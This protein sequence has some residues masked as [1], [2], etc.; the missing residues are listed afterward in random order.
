ARAGRAVPEAVVLLGH[1]QPPTLHDP[2]GPDHP[3]TLARRT[4]LVPV[5]RQQRHARGHEQPRPGR[6]GPGSRLSLPPELHH[7]GLPR[8]R[9]AQ[10]PATHVKQRGGSYRMNGMV[11][12]L[13]GPTSAHVTW[14]KEL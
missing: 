10:L 6:Q 2:G 5:P 12:A 7:H 1:A 14:D 8:M 9:E 13:L 3:K 11:L 4:P